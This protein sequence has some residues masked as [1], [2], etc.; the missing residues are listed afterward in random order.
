MERGLVIQE[1]TRHGKT[2]KGAKKYSSWQVRDYCLQ[3]GS[4][5][6][7]KEFRF[8]VDSISDKQEARQ[9]AEEFVAN[10]AKLGKWALKLL[11]ELVE[12]P[13]AKANDLWERARACVEEA[14]LVL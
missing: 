4:Y 6:L 1:S 10:R 7:L 3:E 13:N 14:G 9:K 5:L 2:V 8:K 12:S 11:K